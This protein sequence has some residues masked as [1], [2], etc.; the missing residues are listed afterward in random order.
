MQGHMTLRLRFLDRDFIAPLVAGETDDGLAG[1]LLHVDLHFG[2]P[3]AQ[4]ENPHGE[5]VRAWVLH[6]RKTT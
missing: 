3:W 5:S 6:T 1:V 2:P 4:K